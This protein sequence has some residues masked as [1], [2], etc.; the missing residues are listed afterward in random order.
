MRSLSARGH[1]DELLKFAGSAKD[2]SERRGD[3]TSKKGIWIFPSVR[4]GDCVS[5]GGSK[6][7]EGH[8]EWA[9]HPYAGALSQG[10]V[11][12]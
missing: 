12:V 11:L 6:G 8:G 4:I 5:L 3:Y 1:A 2:G 7:R 10:T 9:E